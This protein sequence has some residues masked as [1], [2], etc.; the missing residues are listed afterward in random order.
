MTIPV[1]LRSDQGPVSEP[2]LLG[3]NVVIPLWLIV[4]G[5]GVH[6]RSSVMSQGGVVRLV[7]AE[8]IPS[9]CGVCVVA[10]V[11]GWYGTVL[12]ELKLGCAGL[13]L[14]SM[15]VEPDSSDNATIVLSNHSVSAVC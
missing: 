8:L 3:T 15:L 11:E 10:I 7:K 2:C 12:V 13:E 1:Y 9:H 5:P 14:E 6:V 4:P